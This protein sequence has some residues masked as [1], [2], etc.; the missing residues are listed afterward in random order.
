MNYLPTPELPVWPTPVDPLD[1]EFLE[2]EEYMVNA[3]LQKVMFTV[4]LKC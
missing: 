4:F 1:E 2:Q 3:R